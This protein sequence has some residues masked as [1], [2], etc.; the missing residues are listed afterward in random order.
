M[1]TISIKLT[2]KNGF[3]RTQEPICVGIPIEKGV[4]ENVDDLSLLE[5]GI[6]LPCQNTV[7]ALWPDKSI[8]WLLLEFMVDIE[9]HKEKILELQNQN[10]YQNH[11]KRSENITLVIEEQEEHI[12][13]NTGTHQ[14]LL[15]KSEVK[16]FDFVYK[17]E[18]LVSSNE[19]GGVIFEDENNTQFRP[20]IEN[21]SID[22]QEQNICSRVR[23]KGNFVPLNG[24]TTKPLTLNFSAELTFYAG[25]SLIKFQFT[26]HNPNAA[27]H[28]KG[29]WDLG[30]EGSV[31]FKQLSIQIPIGS[32][33]QIKWKDKTEKNWEECSRESFSLFQSSSGG[34]NWQSSNHI[35]SEGKLPL[36][37]KGFQY[38]EK[39]H[40]VSKGERAT[41][42]I[43]VK[44]E[45]LDFCTTIP[46]F[47][48]N[49][50][51][52]INFKNDVLELALFPKQHENLFELQGG[53][54]KTHT[55]FFTFGSDS[56]CQPLNFSQAPLIPSVSAKDY[57]NS[58]TFQWF[59]L[60]SGDS[61]IES[62]LAIGLDADKGFKAKREVIDEYGWRNFG[63]LFAD[64]ESLY[65]ADNEFNI[66]HYNNQYDPIYG[67]LRQFVYTGDE[68]WFQLADELAKHVVD[69][70]IY[71]TERDRPE[72]NGGLFW[73]TDHYVD[74]GTSSHR[75]YSKHQI[76]DENPAPGGGPGGEHCYTSGLLYHY[77]FTGSQS[78]KAAVVSL[79]DWMSRFYEGN[80]GILDRLLRFKNYELPLLKRI[81][82]KEQIPRH[83]YPFTRG[84]GNFIN[85]LLDSFQITSDISYLK[86]VESIIQRTI[87]PSDDIAKRD[88]ANIE[89]SWSYI[90]LLQ[91]LIKYLEIKLEKGEKDDVYYY[92]RDSLIHY[93]DWMTEHEVPY[94]ER[95]D[96]L[97]F[98]NH[99]WVAQDIRKAFVFACSTRY[100]PDKN[101][102]Y[103]AKAE[104]FLN[105]VAVK[106]G[107]HENRSFTR[108]LAILLQNH[109][110]FDDLESQNTRGSE[111]SIQEKR[112]YSE[113]PNFSVSLIVW[114]LFRDIIRRIF[115]LSV[116]KEVA[117]IRTVLK[118]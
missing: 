32:T 2:E 69:I 34:E 6:P 5:S 89:V 56:D 100:N 51:K 62:L 64:H 13:V 103:K 114:E 27:R 110:S 37:F 38:T 95:A 112:I 59:R 46:H 90:I 50:P 29:L 22:H 115:H 16:P 70:D 117:W 107:E 20:F 11:V 23:F 96:V 109:F 75:T 36:Q 30:D 43:S 88:L 72:F 91:S 77:Y 55:L 108:I 10:I 87:H 8:K 33:P 63:E 99:T 15:H 79:T 80:G 71:R 74:A 106:I 92:T 101:S 104:Y 118:R 76:S 12:R 111:R 21:I 47:W 105:Y 26:L 78:S 35:D 4:L 1:N 25:T 98:P 67:F 24:K 54:Q 42:F 84:T 57:E 113:C 102:L 66:S 83:Y 19:R 48:Q 82:K 60:K 31:L 97:E 116:R 45:T 7:T 94:L 58:N 85:C 9:A 28:K 65:K 49:F 86:R 68:R 93:V 52:A 40:I 41:P 18:Q 73:H 3:D 39:G 61:A 44:S 53:E 17:K 81:L 14:I